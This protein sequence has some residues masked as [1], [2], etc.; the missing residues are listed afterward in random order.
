MRWLFGATVTLLIAA[1]LILLY[2]GVESHQAL[3]VF[4]NDLA[5]RTQANDAFLQMTPAERVAKY[6]QL[7]RI[8]PS[9]IEQSLRSQ[10]ATL[11]SLDSLHC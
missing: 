3:C 2:L 4:R 8:P 9:T 5:T 10:Q 6:G 7:G 1:T 11:R